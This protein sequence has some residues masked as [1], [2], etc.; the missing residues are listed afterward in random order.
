M[1]TQKTL[2]GVATLLL[3][4]ATNAGIIDMGVYQYHEETGL[5]W[6]DLSETSGKSIN[7]ALTDNPGWAIATEL[8]FQT[9][10]EWYNGTAGADDSILGFIGGTK[11]SNDPATGQES[12][13]LTN[14]GPSYTS[15]IFATHFGSSHDSYGGCSHFRWTMG[16]YKNETTGNLHDGGVVA[17]D[18]TCHSSQDLITA[19]YDS[20][21][22]QSTNNYNFGSTFTSTFLVRTATNVPEP[23]IISLLVAGL[24][25][26]GLV[27]RRLKI[28]S[29]PLS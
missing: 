2:I 29:K 3:S 19:F 28:K 4:A 27:R 1:D 25:S 17:K 11:Y 6:L 23:S 21:I 22:I 13:S 10:F 7:T 20:P 5:E 12:I 9:M 14:D 18:L 8:Q 24:I 16:F 15:N 26:L